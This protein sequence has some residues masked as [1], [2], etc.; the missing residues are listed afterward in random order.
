[1][2][3]EMTEPK[4]NKFTFARGDKFVAFCQS[5]DLVVIGHNLCW[6]AQLPSWVSKPEPGQATLV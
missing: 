5:H 4:P 6:H 1:M 3:W 2:K